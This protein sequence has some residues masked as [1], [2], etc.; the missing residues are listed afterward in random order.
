[1]NTA[2]L[3]AGEGRR[4]AE[5][6]RDWPPD[7]V[8]R[9]AA[10]ALAAWGEERLGRKIRW[11]WNPRLRTTI[12]RAFLDENLVELNPV[13]LARH[14]AEMRAIVIHEWA[15]LVAAKRRP[16]EPSHGPTWRALMR[17]AGAP[18]RATHRLPVEDLRRG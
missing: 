18:P 5:L 7:A 12:G 4:I 3:V 15:H 6:L 2:E 16:R 17:A 10:A 14:P 8:E 1:M 11:R 9:V 13:L